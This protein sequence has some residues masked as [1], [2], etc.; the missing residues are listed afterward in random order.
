MDLDKAI[1]FLVESQAKHEAHLQGIDSQ[2]KA[3]RKVISGGLK[4][5]VKGQTDTNRKFEA[6]LDAQLR[7]EASI[8]RLAEAQARTADAQSRTEQELRSL[9]DSL[10][11]PKNGRGE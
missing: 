11:H 1:E 8:A 3:I 10:K 9:L 2:L 5:V 7:T 6:L 4:L